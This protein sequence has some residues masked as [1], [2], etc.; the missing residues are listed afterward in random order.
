MQIAS[1]KVVFILDLIKLYKDVPDIL[2]NSLSRILHS[3][4]I[5]KLGTFLC[6]AK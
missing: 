2:D 1:D 4:G 5:L 6:F 3:P